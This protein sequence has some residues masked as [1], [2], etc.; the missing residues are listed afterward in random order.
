MA[1]L[2]QL[3]TNTSTLITIFSTEI[4]IIKALFCIT[5]QYIPRLV[6]FKTLKTKRMIV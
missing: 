6:F 4:K 5:T 2:D 3:G 1:S